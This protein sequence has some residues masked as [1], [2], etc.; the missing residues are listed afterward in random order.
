MNTYIFITYVYIILI[1]KKRR[2]LLLRGSGWRKER[3][4][5]PLANIYRQFC[6][7]MDC[8]CVT[9]SRG[10]GN[11]P[12]DEVNMYMHI[13][14]YLEMNLYVYERKYVE[15]LICIIWCAYA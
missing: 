2:F 15:V 3:G 1:A 5:S 12:V 10:I 4:D 14:L 7:C 11:P 9:V 8:L 13:Y 6:D